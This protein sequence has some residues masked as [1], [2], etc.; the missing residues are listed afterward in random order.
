MALD[1]KEIAI[2]VRNL[3]TERSPAATN[4]TIPHIIALIPTAFGV[5]IE[6]ALKDPD[7]RDYFLTTYTPNLT[8][9]TLDLTNYINGTT[10]EISLSDLRASTIYVTIDSTLTP[11]TWLG[12]Y[13]QLFYDR[14][15]TEI[16]AVFLE[17]KTLMTRD[18]AGSLTGLGTSQIKFTVVTKPSSP[19][20]LPTSMLHEFIT[21]LATL[22]IK[23]LTVD[24]Q[25]RPR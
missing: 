12:S 24:S 18:A 8:A 16:P 2:R 21:F 11:M 19:T 5:W 14:F 4:V 7:K 13:S 15:Q 17:G 1:N 23:E 9:G 10:A 6:Q 22:A 3:V 25:A 20:S